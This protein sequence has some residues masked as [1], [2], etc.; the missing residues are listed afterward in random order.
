LI[1]LGVELVELNERTEAPVNMA[2]VVDFGGVP[3]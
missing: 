3:G 1:D 2:G